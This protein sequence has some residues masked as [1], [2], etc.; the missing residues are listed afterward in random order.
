MT[1]LCCALLAAFSIVDDPL[2]EVEL[3]PVD[4]TPVKIVKFSAENGVVKG[5]KHLGRGEPGQWALRDLISLR[6]PSPTPTALSGIHLRL[7]DEEIV[8]CIAIESASADEFAVRGNLFGSL[9]I[10]S[11]LIIGAVLDPDADE[12]QSERAAEWMKKPR[13]TDALLFRNFDEAKGSFVS[14]ED[15]SVTLEVDG[16]RKATPRNQVL[17]VAFDS[18]LLQSK[19]T[20][21]LHA[22][23]RLTD[24]TRL[25]V[26]SISAPPDHPDVANLQTVLG[27]PITVKREHLVDASIRNGRVTYLSD[28]KELDLEIIP[29]LDEA[30]PVQ[31]DR[32]ATGERMR[33]GG[34]VVAKGLG[35]RSGTRMSFPVE[36]ASRFEA[37]IGLDE[38]AGPLGH[39]IFS[40]YVDGKRVGEEI[41][42]S[43][44]DSPRP[45]SV[46]LAGARKITMVVAFGLRGDV[47]DFADWGDAR[48]V[49]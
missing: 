49:K 15:A 8:R 12:R 40:V 24:G 16:A 1:L 10:P 18:R 19:K 31:R 5:V 37:T 34:R 4:G 33:L 3:I 22:V 14:V 25:R 46:P 44:S 41:S 13:N 6:F 32:A 20:K 26:T 38:S 42:L 45:I 48:L 7:A 21:D 47:Q 30:W 27:S 35:M 36:G 2:A 43:S 28:L 29:Y 39:A 17:A 9:K 11:D 23:V